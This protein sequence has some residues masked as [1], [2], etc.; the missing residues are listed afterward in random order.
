MD[1]NVPAM[2]ALLNLG[3]MSGDFVLLIE[4]CQMVWLIL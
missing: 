1:F 4:L 3:S 2:S